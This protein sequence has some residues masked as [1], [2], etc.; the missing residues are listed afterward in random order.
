MAT[1]TNDLRP[2]EFPN[3]HWALFGL[4][5]VLGVLMIAFTVAT[6][7]RFDVP[8][9]QQVVLVIMSILPIALSYRMLQYIQPGVG[10]ILALTSTMLGYAMVMCVIG[11]FVIPRCC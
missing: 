9:F 11:F 10:L 7:S 4:I 6:G 8:M 5:V 3:I 2:V 1:R